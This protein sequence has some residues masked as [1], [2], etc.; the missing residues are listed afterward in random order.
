MA[1]INNT[2]PQLWRVEPWVLIRIC[3]TEL[4]RFKTLFQDSRHPHLMPLT[5]S[6]HRSVVVQKPLGS[7]GIPLQNFS[8]ISSKHQEHLK[9]EKTL[10]ML[11]FS[12]LKCARSEAVLL[13]SKTV[14]ALHSL[15]YKKTSKRTSNWDISQGALQQAYI[16]L[17]AFSFIHCVPPSD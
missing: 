7:W 12:L 4:S 1:F 2:Y 9:S 13:Q 17:I 15:F 16:N 8:S 3:Q 10:F 11:Y 14:T 5:T 6:L